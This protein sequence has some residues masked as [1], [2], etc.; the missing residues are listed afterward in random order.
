MI[1]ICYSPATNLGNWLFQCAVAC[2][3]SDGVYFY[4]P[5]DVPEGRFDNLLKVFPQLKVVKELPAHYLYYK[6]VGANSLPITRPLVVEG[7][8]LNPIL[9]NEKLVRECFQCPDDIKMYLKKQYKNLFNGRETVG[10]SVRRGDYLRLPDRHPFVGK[11]YLKASVMKFSSRSLFVVCSDDILWC[12][13]FFTHK[14]F[15]DRQFMFIENEGVLEQL[16]IHTFCKHNIISNSTFSWWGAWLNSNLQKTV[17]F[18]SR[19][20]GL[21]IGH[22]WAQPLYFEGCEVVRCS[23]SLG[24]ILR[25]FYRIL[26][27][28]C[29]R[30]LKRLM[31]KM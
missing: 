1:Y 17:I 9:F 24:V 20:Y 23:Y 12:K 26:R 3:A 25:A 10:V 4:V 8:F 31:R 5:M 7:C 16:Y 22:Q 19:W 18:P 15:P 27:R 13:R 28:R 30:I 21:S 6:D 2:S 14:R 11:T 29:G